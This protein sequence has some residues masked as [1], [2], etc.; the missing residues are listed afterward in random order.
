MC[1]ASSTWPTLICQPA[2]KFGVMCVV[3]WA[4]LCNYYQFT[5]GCCFSL[6]VGLRSC[7]FELIVLRFFLPC[8]F[9]SYIP[10]VLQQQTHEWRQKTKK[11]TMKLLPLISTVR[12]TFIY[13]LC[14]M[15][16]FGHYIFINPAAISSNIS[17]F[18]PCC[19][20]VRWAGNASHLA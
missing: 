17:L 12:R 16:T 18:C 13:D 14:F 1:S 9:L 8:N 6:V 7:T 10:H 2:G 11:V 5:I 19:L 4:G 3:T 15:H 20:A